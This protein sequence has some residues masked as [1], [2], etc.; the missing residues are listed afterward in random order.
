MKYKVIACNV[1]LREVCYCV[2]RSPHRVDLEFM[3][4]GEHVDSDRLRS[5]L[6][7]KIDEADANPENYDAILLVYGLCGNS[8]NGL[9]AG[10]KTPVVLPRA[11]D[12]AT[13]LLG[14]KALFEK[15]FKDNPSLP[16]SSNGY[17]ERSDYYLRAED[18]IT[19]GAS[20]DDLVKEYGEDN[21]AF[22][23]ETM[24][25]KPEEPRAMFIDI[26][27]VTSDELKN[28]F[29]AEAEADNKECV[30]LK[31]CMRLIDNLVRGQWDERDFL[32]VP[33][34]KKIVGKYDWEDVV[35]VG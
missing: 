17:Y 7:E 28:K 1:F 31:G 20:Y 13:I 26:P 3:H 35:D 5:L 21:A 32:V 33:P 11:H 19:G 14:D 6:Q 27:E 12:C 2:A 4:I 34:G 23:W 15:H 24:N 8:T 22:L 25:A 18:S 10:K 29:A 16:F 30:F 9:K